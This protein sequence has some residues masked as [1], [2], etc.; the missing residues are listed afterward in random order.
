MAAL[1]PVQC[2]QCGAKVDVDPDDTQTTCRY[3]GTLSWV[4]R[5][6]VRRP[7]PP[8]N[9]RVIYVPAP[10]QAQWPGRKLQ[11]TQSPN[12]STLGV[13]VAIGLAVAVMGAVVA[14]VARGSA[15]APNTP[16]AVKSVAAATPPV[17]R[18]PPPPD[19]SRSGRP[20]VQR[21][22]ADDVE[23]LIVYEGRKSAYVAIDG[24]TGA[25][26]WTGNQTSAPRSRRAFAYV[27][28]KS[29]VVVRGVDLSLVDLA[30]G[31]LARAVTLDDH[32]ELPCRA[33]T[34][35]LRL[36]LASNEVAT[37]DMQTG[38]AT[39]EKK[40]ARCDEV[41]SD[42]ESR[43]G[44][45]ERRYHPPSSLPA[46][47]AALRC[48]SISVSG[49]WTY[50]HPDPCGPKL[51]I[52]EDGLGGFAPDVAIALEGGYALVGVRGR[53]RRT[54]MIGRVERGKLVWSAPVSKLEGAAQPQEQP[55]GVAVSGMQVALLTSTG[56]T[57]T[58]VVFDGV[59]GK[60]ALEVGLPS[61]ARLVAPAHDRW[62]VMS[63]DALRSVSKADGALQTLVQ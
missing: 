62:F 15:P 20:M 52:S 54:A 23:D 2:P 13:L 10:P 49:T 14:L 19:F 63:R 37:V 22:N 61:E 34:G 44:I 60:R 41:S 51:G 30:K 21:I 18:A 48:G 36:L 26:I 28:D 46:D 25:T 43:E 55:F 50:F 11:P 3:C 8:P 27:A 42:L 38:A 45:N 47:V 9:T 5:P 24:K 4:Q 17:P 39:L 53:G 33:P 40:G 12:R 58:L 56:K 35:K 16:K 57:D 1:V 32:A 59:S 29:V 6:D 7:K 31:T